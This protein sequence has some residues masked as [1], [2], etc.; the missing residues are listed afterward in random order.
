[1]NLIKSLRA[2]GDAMRLGGTVMRTGRLPSNVEFAP[3]RKLRYKEIAAS[4]GF[5]TDAEALAGDWRR[6]G[7]YL[8]TAMNQLK[9]TSEQDQ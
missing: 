8:R 5:K 3:P 7:D 1:M 6:V 4:D 2:A 9:G